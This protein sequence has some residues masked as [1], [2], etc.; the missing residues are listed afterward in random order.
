MLH[1]TFHTVAKSL[2]FLCAGNVYQRFNT[3][4][5]KKIKGGVM[6]ALP[7]RPAS[8]FCMAMLA[9]VGM[10]P[11]SLFQS[12]FLVVSRGVQRG[13]ISSRDRCSFCLESACSRAW[14]CMSAAWCWARPANP[15]PHC[16]PWRDT[17]IL[18]LVVVLV[19][20]GFWLPG[21]LLGLIRG[22]ARV[23]NGE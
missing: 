18:A 12:E 9:I 5:F 20:I 14:R 13:T 7:S 21:P 19:V 10:P 3:D 11:F 1:M 6:R 22:A 23:V 2:L 15:A 4:L 17:A 8:C 16:Y